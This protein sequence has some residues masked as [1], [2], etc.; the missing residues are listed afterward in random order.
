MKIKPEIT[1]QNIKINKVLA[2]IHV[3]MFVCVCAYE[4]QVGGGG[5]GGGGGCRKRHGSQ[6]RRES[7]YSIYIYMQTS[8]FTISFYRNSQI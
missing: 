8:Y 6:L 3:S 5:G 2:D 7:V 1:T 4:E